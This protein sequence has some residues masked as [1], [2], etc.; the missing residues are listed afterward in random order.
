ML[1]LNKYGKKAE[2]GKIE[3]KSLFSED[4]YG[5]WLTASGTRRLQG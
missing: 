2:H 4:L 3:E 1:W 5:L